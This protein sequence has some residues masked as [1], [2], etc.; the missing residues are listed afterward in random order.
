MSGPELN[1]SG[2]SVETSR[3]ID[4]ESPKGSTRIV[5]GSYRAIEPGPSSPFSTLTRGYS[6]NI[7]T[8]SKKHQGGDSGSDTCPESSPGL[9]SREPP[10]TI[11]AS[12]GFH[13]R[14]RELPRHIATLPFNDPLSLYTDMSQSPFDT[15]PRASGPFK[16]NTSIG[17]FPESNIYRNPNTSSDTFGWLGNGYCGIP[18]ETAR[19]TIISNDG[20][21]QERR[22]DIL[23]QFNPN[24]NDMLT[25]RQ[26]DV[27]IPRERTWSQTEDSVYNQDYDSGSALGNRLLPWVQS[28]WRRIL[29]MVIFPALCVVA[30]CSVPI[31]MTTIKN[32]DGNQAIAMNFWFFLFFYYGIYSAV[33]LLL[34][35]QIFRLYSLNWW[36]KSMSG[37]TANAISWMVAMVLGSA[38]YLSDWGWAH[39]PFTW[40]GITLFTLLFPVMMSFSLIQRHHQ[41][42]IRRQSM[43][44]YQQ[45]FSSSVEWR[46]PASYRR[47]LWFCSTFLLWYI[48]LTAGEYLAYEYTSTLPH[49]SFVGLQYV[50][51]WIGII[52]ILDAITAWI[53]TVKVQSWP[54]LYIYQLYFSITY[55][56]F[57]RNLFARLRTPSQVVLVQLGSSLWVVFIFPFRMARWVHRLLCRVFGFDTTYDEYVRSLSRVFF[58]R[59]VAENV[60]ML[61]FLCWVSI[62]HFGPN[63]KAYPYF[64]FNQ[65]Y[66][67]PN[68]HYSYEL[69]MMASALVWLSEIVASRVVRVIV[70]LIYSHSI[71][72]SVVRDFMRYPNM[73][74]AMILIMDQL[75]TKNPETF[76]GA[77]NKNSGYQQPFAEINSDDDDFYYSES[78]IVDISDLH[79]LDTWPPNWPSQ[80]LRGI[81][82]NLKTPYDRLQFTLVHPNWSRF[83][84]E[85]LWQ[86]PEFSS[87]EAF[88]KFLREARVNPARMQHIRSLDL[89]LREGSASGPSFSTTDESA[90]ATATV[91]EWLSN[92]GMVQEHR[93]IAK[94]SLGDHK[95]LIEIIRNTEQIQK[96]AFYGYKVVDRDFVHLARHARTLN[97]LQI[98][99]LPS[100]P[101][102]TLLPFFRAL[103]DI[104]SIS[105]ILDSVI[106]QQPGGG[107]ALWRG[108]QIRADRLTKLDIHV[109]AVSGA[110]IGPILGACRSLQDL[111]IVG[112]D[113]LEIDD[114]VALDVIKNNPDLEFLA[115]YGSGL[116]S[117]PV[118]AALS[119]CPKLR[120]LE[121]IRTSA[122]TNEGMDE[123]SGALF[124]NHAIVSRRLESLILRGF[125][126]E[127]VLFHKLSQLDQLQLNKL[128]LTEIHSVTTEAIIALLS[129]QNMKLGFKGLRIVDCPQISD[130]ILD[131]LTSESL[132]HKET[133]EVLHIQGCQFTSAVPVHRCVNSLS[134]LSIVHVS[135]TEMIPH[136]FQYSLGPSLAKKEQTPENIPISTSFQ[137]N[138]PAGHPLSNEA[139][140][141]E[142]TT[143]NIDINQSGPALG[144]TIS[145]SSMFS[146]P[147]TR[148][149]TA[150]QH[151]GSRRH[152]Q[153]WIDFFKTI[154]PRRHH[155][156]TPS[157]ERGLGGGRKRT[158]SSLAVGENHGESSDNVQRPITGYDILKSKEEYQ[159]NLEPGIDITSTQQQ[160]QP[161]EPSPII[162]I[163]N[164][165]AEDNNSA[166]NNE[167]AESRGLNAE[168]VESLLQITE[169]PIAASEGDPAAEHP[170]VSQIVEE[171][172]QEPS[173]RVPIQAENNTKESQK[174]D[175][176]ETTVN[177][178]TEQTNFSQQ[179]DQ[180]DDTKMGVDQVIYG[181]NGLPDQA[182]SDKMH[183][184][185]Q[186]QPEAGEEF[187]IQEP[188][189]IPQE[190][191]SPVG[192][193]EHK[194][195]LPSTYPPQQQTTAVDMD[196]KLTSDELGNNDASRE[197]QNEAPS[198]D[199]DTQHSDDPQDISSDDSGVFPTSVE[200]GGNDVPITSFPKPTNEHVQ[201]AVS[202][203]DQQE[204][205]IQASDSPP[206]AQQTN[207]HS[208]PS[209]GQLENGGFQEHSGSL[210]QSAIPLNHTGEKVYALDSQQEPLHTE[211]EAQLEDTAHPSQGLPPPGKMDDPAPKSPG[212]IPSSSVGNGASARPIENTKEIEESYVRDITKETNDDKVD[213]KNLSE[214]PIDQHNAA[215]TS[216]EAAIE[217]QQQPIVPS[218]PAANSS[219]TNTFSTLQKGKE[220]L[221]QPPLNQDDSAGQKPE[222]IQNDSSH[223]VPS[224]GFANQG[225]P[226]QKFPG[227]FVNTP[228]R[229]QSSY[230][231][232]SHEDAVRDYEAQ[233][234]NLGSSSNNPFER[235][236]SR[237]S[238]GYRDNSPRP[239]QSGQA[240]LIDPSPGVSASSP[241][242]QPIAFN[243][244][245]QPRPRNQSNN[246]R[247]NRDSGIFD[248]IP[249]ITSP[250]IASTIQSHSQNNVPPISLPGTS[251]AQYEAAADTVAAGNGNFNG[252]EIYRRESVE[253]MSPIT[254]GD[255][256]PVLSPQRELFSHGSSS[257]NGLGVTN[258]A[259]SRLLNTPIFPNLSNRS[260]KQREKAPTTTTAAAEEPMRNSLPA[261]HVPTPKLPTASHLLETSNASS[262]N[263]TPSGSS[264]QP[265]QHKNKTL[266][267]LSVETQE[268]GR[269]I[270]RVAEHDDPE[271]LAN[272]FCQ[273]YKM[274][275]LSAGLKSLIISKLERKKARRQQKAANKE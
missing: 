69:T 161:P 16:E 31:P 185:A 269:Q 225:T 262:Q 265:R 15:L 92:S 1:N 203:V 22:E 246:E 158:A 156:H 5:Y 186:Q 250:T 183:I 201:D 52:Y 220:P 9:L 116:T 135:G 214:P 222:S 235:P 36:P 196:S 133:L 67:D 27:R 99:G 108:L 249:D 54:L 19:N 23:A 153:K 113:R 175:S 49:S 170:N 151:H 90:L 120:H 112:T 272:Q 147:P 75:E 238:V 146:D 132:P 270:L 274:M 182:L 255:M 89:T 174:L 177:K 34:V 219:P 107:D 217:E 216:P 105:I 101:P 7:S 206:A 260:D 128:S 136:H 10:E 252:G 104:R 149:M 13:A 202:I 268:F 56:I 50:Y 73:I 143:D 215:T 126:V 233:R 129:S 223:E 199:Q 51:S 130:S 267:E 102:R 38:A 191:L 84:L 178:A 184:E 239:F 228:P 232:D 79:F 91:L 195:T 77:Q 190:T 68:N 70:R 26:T 61:G 148:P 145:S 62:L 41:K 57:Y 103:T 85:V 163:D 230:I 140:Y 165:K 198:T 65:K 247:P 256:D 53:I 168:A 134:K 43:N 125:S 234:R 166:E 48:G 187:S 74:P 226:A 259:N 210:S 21:D 94:T 154:S 261:E 205:S 18:T 266:L 192:A 207:G 155:S 98:I 144:R 181:E 76:D 3:L 17:K 150:S 167:N 240:V 71:S 231:T 14:I 59:N 197:I 60:T 12:W 241:R 83:G 4:H 162:A 193:P 204:R 253:T 44:E 81:A 173:N 97:E 200:Q 24:W 87:P 20:E 82:Q 157:G 248:S 124:A 110:E 244:Q 271:L 86:E 169:N 264:K 160:S 176:V 80:I 152:T 254:P 218:Q 115:L 25:F 95:L 11:D 6:S 2:I 55:F 45:I 159:N 172:D 66:D 122:S 275:D 141:T 35:T 96:L 212:S 237:A 40:T 42:S 189:P 179:L 118:F 63:K 257:N 33:A 37:F 78:E 138:F 243:N 28:A 47:F 29:L 213:Q 137:A 194:D 30:W 245:P 258:S 142:S 106:S 236:L 251:S 46:V 88:Y 72:N 114:N 164:I 273:K 8:P 64:Q 224:D 171:K 39:E 263:Q 211:P 58:L 100:E 93:S 32:N 127:D 208:N 123:S 119:G 229:V 111:R 209:P 117:V 242:S 227:A 131:P 121:V 221:S 139:K 109:P 180:I 188:V